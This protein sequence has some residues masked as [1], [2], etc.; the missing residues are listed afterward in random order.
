MVECRG[1]IGGGINAGGLSE[2]LMV[3]K[4]LAM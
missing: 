3:C 1:G 4:V 2:I